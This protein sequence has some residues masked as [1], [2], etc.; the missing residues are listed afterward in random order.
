M[1]Q[2][3]APSDDN[4]AGEA[5]RRSC[6]LIPQ[7]DRDEA[8]KLLFVAPVSSLNRV[9]NVFPSQDALEEVYNLQETER[10]ARIA[11]CEAFAMGQLERLGAGSQVR[12]LEPE[13]LRM[14]LEQGGADSVAKKVYTLD[15]RRL[16]NLKVPNT[17]PNEPHGASR[18]HEQRVPP[19]HQQ[20]LVLL[21]TSAQPV[22]A[23]VFFVSLMHA[24]NVVP[25]PPACL[26]GSLTKPPLRRCRSSTPRRL[27][28]SKFHGTR[29][30]GR[31]GK[32]GSSTLKR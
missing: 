10:I 2:G 21:Q 31:T 4:V 23:S 26:P 28:R 29:C 7:L 32:T 13:V 30:S 6:Y 16:Q 17:H 5:R 19:I 14:V 3:A 12:G 11:K 25:L 27:A 18:S 20:R 9:P 22:P 15:G 1:H 24:G 8:V